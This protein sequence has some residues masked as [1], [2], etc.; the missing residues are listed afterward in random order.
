MKSE[1]RVRPVTR[2]IV[3]HYTE[4][5]RSASVDQIGEYP[6]EKQAELVAKVFAAFHGAEFIAQGDAK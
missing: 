3:T 2:Y 1:F 6:N 4:K 5:G